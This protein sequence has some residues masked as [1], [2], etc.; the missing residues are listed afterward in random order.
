MVGINLSC[1][2]SFFKAKTLGKTHLGLSSGSVISWFVKLANY[3]TLFSISLI[4]IMGEIYYA[5]FI[6]LL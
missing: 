5:K 2:Y 1:T 4:S 6:V 3:L